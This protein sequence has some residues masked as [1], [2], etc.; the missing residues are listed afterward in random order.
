MISKNLSSIYKRIFRSAF[1]SER[2]P[3]EITL[4]AVSKGFTI[5]IIKEAADCG[6]RIFGENRVQEALDKIKQFEKI[7]IINGYNNSKWHFIGHLQGN[8]VRPVVNYFDFIHSVDSADLA[9]QIDKEASKIE[10]I[11]PIL[12]Q[13]KLSDEVTKFGVSEDKL[14]QLI[15][16]VCSLKNISLQGLMT[17]PPF[18]EDPEL[19]RPYFKKLKTLRDESEKIYHINLP[20]L[21]M[22]MSK[23]FEVAIE[24]G[25]TMIRIGTALLGER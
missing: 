7:A 6:I 22:G 20:H 16:L 13:V 9:I 5:E 4:I 1:K 3:D 8:K 23:D 25:A 12:I 11:Q 2:N 18:N 15:E 21:S 19:S 17:I 10:K 14:P 24:E